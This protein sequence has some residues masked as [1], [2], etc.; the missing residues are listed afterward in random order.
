MIV[1]GDP[2]L[3]SRQERA[4]RLNAHRAPLHPVMA[5][6]LDPVPVL[7][8]ENERLR[9]DNAHLRAALERMMPAP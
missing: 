1:M 2:Q 6:W 8:E 4:D 9:T 5:T 7:V 3:V